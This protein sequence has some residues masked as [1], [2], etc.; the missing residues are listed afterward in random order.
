METV[1]WDDCQEFVRKL[2]AHFEIESFRLRFALPTEAQWEYACRAGTTDAYGGNGRLDDMGWY[3]GN[4]LGNTCPVGQ[5]RANAWGLY[6]M[7][8][9]VWEWCQDLYGSYPDGAQTDPPGAASGFIRF[10]R[11]RVL[12]GG[13]YGDPPRNCRSATRGERGPDTLATYFGLRLAAIQ[14]SPSL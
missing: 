2:N 8:G 10:L 6:D 14:N 7:H 1:S 9:N 4:H 12:R 5:K 13:G 3:D 11:G